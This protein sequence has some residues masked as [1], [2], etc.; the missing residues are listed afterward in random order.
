MELNLTTASGNASK[1]TVEVSEETFNKDFNEA[2]IHQVVTAYI[3]GTRAGTKAQKNRSEVSGGGAKPWRQKGTGRARSGTIRSPIWRSGGTTFAASNRDFSQKVN[4]KMYRS[5]MTSIV[6]ELVRQ[7]RL[8]VLSDLKM[9]G[10][11]TKELADQLK[12]L[13]CENA[14]IVT[15]DFD[16]NIYLSSRNL[17]NI[18][19]TDAQHINPVNLVRYNKVIMTADAVKKVEEMLK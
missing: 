11:K 3:A 10:P 15:Q 12:T 1:K 6:S 18:E 7:E 2:L 14:L 9:D 4:R 16:Q 17:I 13:G 19:Y 8:V 5:A